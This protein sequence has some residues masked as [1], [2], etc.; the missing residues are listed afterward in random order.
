MNNNFLNVSG[1][2]L[3]LTLAST[4]VVLAQPNDPLASELIESMDF[5]DL[6]DMNVGITSASK[7]LETHFDSA[8]AIHVLSGEDLVKRGIVEIPEALRLVPGLQ[9]GKLSSNEWNVTIRGNGGQY[10]RNVLV[11]IDGR[12]I[13]DPLFSGVLW[14]ELNLAMETIDRI[15]VVRGPS[16]TIWGAN[17]VNGVINI[18]TKKASDIKS[19]SLTITAGDELKYRVSGL[20]ATQLNDKTHLRLSANHQHKEGF[21]E[22]PKI[23]ESGNSTNSRISLALDHKTDNGNNLD[24]SLDLFKHDIDT[25]WLDTRP[26]NIINSPVSLYGLRSSN[27]DGYNI[28][29]HWTQAIGEHQLFKVRISA[30]ETSRSSNFDRWDTRNIDADLE[31][32]FNYDR[33]KITIGTNNRFVNSDTSIKA[34]YSVFFVPNEVD[35]STNSLFISDKIS[36]TDKLDVTAGIRYEK[37][38]GVAGYLQ[39]TL[40][41]VWKVNDNNRLWAAL[42]KADSLPARTDTDIKNAYIFAIPANFQQ[43]PIP[44]PTTIISLS[45]KDNN[46]SGT[47]KS[48]EMGYR[49]N[50]DGK[51]SADVSLFYSEYE[52]LIAGGMTGQRNINFIGSYPYVVLEAVNKS[53]G[54]AKSSGIEVALN[55]P[56]ND[57]FNIQYTGHYINY[58]DEQTF[59]NGFDINRGFI[60]ANVDNPSHEHSLRFTS[61][62]TSNLYLS[63]DTSWVDEIKLLN[64][65]SYI[66]SNF[67]IKYKLNNNWEVSLYGNNIGGDRV[68][69]AREALMDRTV[70]IPSSYAIQTK[71]TF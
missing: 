33:Q 43:Q 45:G 46:E 22:F 20:T 29:A 41:S 40:R 69:G 35:I 14:E 37:S 48:L 26:Q 34:G 5:E 4:S 36:F 61:Q 15:E 30:D 3:G 62:V 7:R 70:E 64:I 9:V 55:I 59:L 56:V 39:G 18:V 1:L 63:L 71:F 58:F 52:N 54:G 49:Y 6:M 42:S 67:A 8:A 17:A 12:S 50:N 31:Y 53:T 57:K 27:I 13:Y 21:E 68:E 2:L 16:G 38:S 44:R 19:S 66:S 23:S 47:S 65:D 24:L 25:F 28:Q 51:F 32:Q 11:L 10:A 60:R